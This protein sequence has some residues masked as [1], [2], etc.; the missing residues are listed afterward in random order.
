M[1]RED[2]EEQEVEARG[3]ALKRLAM[4]TCTS[5]YALVHTCS[6]PAFPELAGTPYERPGLF[7][8]LSTAL[9][10]LRR[11]TLSFVVDTHIFR[12]MMP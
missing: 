3:L 10:Y 5:R 7:T 4:Q 6:V 1:E 8:L 12:F 11:L 9:Y 2:R